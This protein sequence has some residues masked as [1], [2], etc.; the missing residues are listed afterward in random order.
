MRQSADLT[1]AELNQFRA[2]GFLLV[3]GL[4]D[5]VTDLDPILAEYD[6]VLGRLAEA[7]YDRGD[8]RSSYAE[9]PFAER[10]VTV[11]RE[12]GR[13]FAQHFDFSLPQQGIAD[14]TPMWLGPAVFAALVNPRLLDAVASVI[15]SE[16]YS[17]P[18]QHVRIKPPAPALNSG[19]D[20]GS[21]VQLTPWHQDNG[22]VRPTADDTD[23]LTVWFSLTDASVENGCVQVIPRSHKGGIHTHCFSPF[24]M[25][26]PDGQLMLDQARPIP[27][28]RG[29]VLFLHKR[30]CHGS[31]PNVSADV[32]C[33]LDLRYNPIGQATGREHF[34]GF[35]ARSHSAPE[36]AMRDPDTWMALWHDTRARLAA[37][38][39]P[40]VFHRWDA[41]D[42]L[43]A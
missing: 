8:L 20:G 38:E 14:D 19:A 9:L 1:A 12:T 6:G 43:C 5:P 25:H 18:V 21:L 15:G 29:D 26:I 7:L 35:I 23:M 33:S 40:P 11:Y 42:P 30:T 3:E 4:L 22:V 24:G 13:V 37:V 34:P 41:D 31:L 39:R 2:D 36:S 10:L 28:R 16:I 17:N 32:R 27:A